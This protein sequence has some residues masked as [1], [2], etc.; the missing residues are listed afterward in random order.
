MNSAMMP[1]DGLYRKKTV[2]A[3]VFAESFRREAQIHGW[4]SY[5]GY[6]NATKVLSNLLGIT[7]P[8]TRQQTVLSQSDLMFCMQLTYRVEPAQ[9][10]GN[11]H[12]DR[13]EDYV[14]SIVTF[15]SL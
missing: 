9:K 2:S 11:Q 10:A 5:I 8:L 7:V 12:G 6:P 15:D 3:T 1:V 13:L 4:E 14:F